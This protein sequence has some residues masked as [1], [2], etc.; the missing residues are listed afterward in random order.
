M[1]KLLLSILMILSTL[2]L[3]S[4]CADSVTVFFENFDGPTIKTRTSTS[5]G[6][7]DWSVNTTLYTSP[8]K[9]IHSPL[10]QTT[11]LQSQLYIDTIRFIP[12]KNKIYLSFNHICKI[13]HLDQAFVSYRVSTGGTPGSP[14]WSSW[15][16]M[17]FTE[18]SPNYYGEATAPGA[19][20]AG[21]F[22]Q[23]TYPTLWQNNNNNATP[24]NS[25]WK[26]EL[27][28]ISQYIV[29]LGD[30]QYFEI[31]FY[32]NRMFQSQYLVP[33]GWFLDDIRIVASDKELI[34]PKIALA[35]PLVPASVNHIGP[36]IVKA[37]VTDRPA[38]NV[39]PDSVK[40]YYREDGGA[41]ILA[42]KTQ[43]SA[44]QY[45]WTIPVQC[46][47]TNIQYQITAQ[48]SA[49]NPAIPLDGQFTVNLSTAGTTTNGVQNLG[50]YDPPFAV[51]VGDP[52]PVEVIIKNRTNNPMTSATITL[53]LNGVLQSTYNW[54]SVTD[55][56]PTRPF[57][58]DFIDTVNIGTYTPVMGWDTVKVCVTHR[59]GTPNNYV[60]A[61][62]HCSQYIRFGCAAIL[63]GPLN[64]GGAN[65]DFNTLEDFFITLAN[66]GMNGPIIA[67]LASGTYSSSQFQF[68]SL[69]VG[70][71]ATNTIT[72][73]P[74]SG[75]AADVTIV[76]D[77]N[78]SGRGA[79]TIN[80]TGHLTFN[81]LTIQGKTGGT[82]SMGVVFTG[83]ICT[84]V[85]ITNCIINISNSTTTSNLFS[86]IARIQA[87]TGSSGD[88]E[89]EIRGNTIT[90]GTYGIHY[91]GTSPRTNNLIAIESNTIETGYTGIYTI[92]TNCP[93]YNKNKIKQLATSQLRFTGM[94]IE[95]SS[96]TTSISKNKIWSEN[97]TNVGILLNNVSNG[98]NGEILVSNN[99]VNARAL[100]ANTYGISNTLCTRMN[101]LHNT[102]RLFSTSTLDLT[103]CYYHTSGAI[104][105]FSN[106]ILVNKC[107][108]LNN[109]NYP[110]YYQTN[111]N[112][113]VADYNV[114]HSSGP[115]GY[116]IVA[117]NNIEEWKFAMNNDKDTATITI[118][119][120]F[121]NLTT[122]LN[123]S[124]FS[125]F[126]CPKNI[127]VEDDIRDS[128]RNC[129]VTH[130]GCYS[131]Y[132]PPKDLA[133]V[134][135][136]SPALGTCPQASYP[137][138]LKLFNYGCS[139]INFAN[140][141]ATVTTIATGGLTLNT[142]H[143]IN[144]GTLAPNNSMNITVN[145]GL[146][147][148]HN[149][150]V[151][152][153]FIVNYAGDE[154]ALNDTL[155]L[156]FRLEVIAPAIATYDETFSNGTT[157][158]W[159]IEQISGA[160]N[161]SFQEGISEYPT[162]APVYGTGRLFF[163][164]KNFLT[165][166]ASRA[167]MPV[168]DLTNSVNP[169][170]EV[171]YAHD[172][173]AASAAYNQEGVIVKISTDGGATWTALN[174]ETPNPTNTNTSI[175]KRGQT[176]I[177]GYTLPA[178]VKY[179]YDLSNYNNNGCVFICL[180][181]T[182]KRGNNIN[183]DRIRVRKIHTNDCAV[184]N[185]YTVHERPTVVETSPEIKAIVTNEGRNAQNNVQVTLTVSGANS[186][187]ETATIA[188]IPYN[189]QG[190]ATF[191]GAHLPN[192]G[193]N[194]I[195]VTCQN[196]ENNANNTLNALLNTTA[197][198]I[199]YADTTSHHITF[200][201]VT[202]IKAAAKYNVVDTVI[203]TS[204][205][206][207]PSNAMDAVGKRV[208]AFVS[209]AE[210]KIIT[211]SDITTLTSEMIDSW[212]TL[213]INNYA[214]TNTCTDFYIGI[215]TVDPGHY[216]T[217]QYESP[218]RDETFYFLSDTI[219]TPQTVGRFM[220]GATVETKIDKEFAILS[221]VNPKTDCDLGVEKIKIKIANNGPV[222][223]MP[224]TTLHY[225]INGGAPVTE[226][227]TDT[228]FGRQIKHFSFTV[229]YNFTNNQINIDDNYTVK[230]WVDVVDQDRVRFNDTIFKPIVSMGKAN[231]PIAPDT[232]L[233][234][235]STP[236]TLTAQLPPQIDP[237]IIQWFTKDEDNHFVGP[238]YQ[239]PGPY[240]TPN[241]IFFDTTYY[242][243]VA[244]G[245][246]YTPISGNVANMN[247]TQP[248]TFT[249]G[250][251]RGRVL[252]K[253]SD[254]GNYG[255][256]AKI[257]VNVHSAANGILG[258]PLK[259]YIKQ[260]ELDTLMPGDPFDFENEVA[261]ATLVLDEQYFFNTTGWVEF[262]I[263]KPLNYSSGNIL[264]YTE[265]N[266]GGNNCSAA[267]GGNAYA[268]FKTSPVPYSVQTR[269]AN[270]APNFPPTWGPVTANRM[271]VK[272]FIADMDCAS[273]KVP[274]QLHV[275]DKPT[276]DVQTDALVHPIPSPAATQQCALYQEHI[277][278]VY[279]NLLDIPIPANKV[280]AKAGFRNGTSGPYTWITH[281]I[282]EEFAPL[283]SKTVT[284]TQTYDF[285][286]PTLNRNIQFIILSDLVGESIVFRMNDTIKGTIVSTRTVTIPDE[287]IYTGNFTETFQIIPGI[288]GVNQYAFYENDTTSST[289]HPMNWVPNYTTTNLYDTTVYYMNARTPASPNC[290]T[291]KIP[292]T[293]NVA[294]PTNNHD[295][296]T[297]E[298]IDPISYTCGLL[299]TNLTVN[300]N[301]TDSVLIP[302][303]TFKVTAKFTGNHNVTVVDTITH[304][305]DAVDRL[306]ATQPT[307]NITFNNPV[308]LGSTLENR[309]YN[310]S[311]FTDPV[312][313]TY[314][315]Y[316]KNDTITGELR[317]PG[318]PLAPAN[319]VYTVP[320]GQTLTI[321]PLTHNSNAGTP[322]NKVTFYDT[323]GN[324]PLHSGT[325]YTT[326]NI[327]E[328]TQYKYDGRII[329]PGFESE[330]I[331]GNV[332]SQNGS[333]PFVFTATES[334]GA[335][336][337]KKDELGGYAAL[338]DTI[339]IYV[340]N[341]ITGSF[342]IQIYL[343]NVDTNLLAPGQYNWNTQLLNGATLV[344]D[345]TP[346]FSAGWL[347]IPIEGGFYYT[348][349]SLM[350]LTS[351]NCYGQPNVAA[352][353]IQPLPT[354]KYTGVPNNTAVI[355]RA[356][357]ASTTPVQ[358]SGSNQRITMRFAM[359]YTCESPK[360]NITINTNVPGV[361]LDV[362][363][364][365]TPITP[366]SN[367]PNNQTVVAT[368][369]NRGTSNA[370]GFTVGYQYGNN[371][372][373]E[374]QFSG[375][376][377]AGAT[378]NFTFNTPVDLS[379]VYFPASFMVYVRHN[380]DPF[381]GNDTL[382]IK[383]RQ[384]DPCDPMVMI[385]SRNE[386]GAH[387][388]KFKL[389]GIDHGPGTPIFNCPVNITGTGQY[390][391]FT[392]TVPPGQL[393]RGQFFPITIVNSFST[394][395][396]VNL[397]KYV[398]LDM[399]KDNQFTVDELI[400]SALNVPAPNQANQG[401][402]TTTGFTE[403][404][405]INS[406][407]GLTRLRVITSN[408][409]LSLSMAPCAAFPAGEV[410]DYAIE[411]LD[412]YDIDPGVTHVLHP[413]GNV[414][415]D[416]GAKVKLLV[417]N[418]GA[419]TITFTEDNP[420]NISATVS[421]PVNGT[422]NN[423][424]TSG[425]LNQWETMVVTIHNVDLSM[426]GNYIVDA[427]VEYD[428]D[429]F[430]INNVA[431]SI[432][433]VTSTTVHQLPLS[434]N[435]DADDYLPGEEN[436]FPPF[437]TATS[438]HANMKWD[439]DSLGT[440]NFP[441]AGPIYDHTFRNH[442][443]RDEGQYAV[444]SAPANTSSS[445]VATLST[446]CINFHYNNGY[447]SESDYWQ[448]IFGAANAT[449]KFYVEIGSG[450]YYVTLD[451]IIGRTHTSSPEY[452]LKRNIVMDPIDEN[453]RVRFVV[454]GRTGRIDP[455][456]D[457]IS[458][459][460]GKA[461]I[462]IDGFVYPL[463]FTVADDDC[464]I[465]GDSVFPIVTIKNVGRVT[466]HTFTIHYN[467]ALGTHIQTTPEESWNG[468][469][470]PGETL[471]YTFQHGVL[472]PS[473]HNYL[474]FQALIET[475]NDENLQNNIHTITA[476]TTVGIDD[477][478][479]ENGVILG[480]NMPNP[481]VN[482]TVI[483]FYTNNP[484]ETVLQIHS[485]EGKLLHS[486]V[487]YAEVGENNIEV[488]TSNFAPGVYTYTITINQTKLT[489]KMII[490]K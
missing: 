47:G 187:T 182:G 116:Y 445:A 2:V 192:N 356:G 329:S 14:T 290:P 173:T 308:T 264:I 63:S 476:C 203:V 433:T 488:N 298:L 194:N 420:L 280:L 228:I 325:S 388:S 58:L 430:T 162:I 390:S 358:F 119:P 454:T 365:V 155:S 323:S 171:W 262:P 253:Q 417:K 324:D 51:E 337:Y 33:T 349:N 6:T 16:N 246:L 122:S 218:T 470:K 198:N 53:S 242:V 143:T 357:V 260:T 332:A 270:Q 321:S 278:V 197:N 478:Q 437:W 237:G 172:N 178:W 301:N 366:N 216:L 25:W 422:Y 459:K 94:N 149:Q 397:Y 5:H 177:T 474:Q 233:V 139:T 68:N 399:N 403:E 66:C 159:K 449:C 169:I 466:I 60:P 460:H 413:V 200:G 29:G 135:M 41:P 127:L 334:Q 69:F 30:G 314:Q 185:I 223:I 415:A 406:Q 482:E 249:S 168:M 392:E 114:Y 7:A 444:V 166:T 252:Y 95:R 424:I 165:N 312:D 441:Q 354:F 461:D 27:I 158:T 74:Q 54:S 487:Y 255:T 347:H 163:N 8:S 382:R 106:N 419:N 42:P 13:H 269:T 151:N 148:P 195:S 440:P 32:T 224:G 368:I 425:T 87:A 326:P 327:Y 154:R 484:G 316:R 485:I 389:G 144:T 136:I 376:I 442:F 12:G 480:Q 129:E 313:P 204:V 289:L 411:I 167:I 161:W 110:I 385:G 170:L 35:P 79:I 346:N 44:T 295:L 386:A 261:D 113:L 275:P 221:L 164:S 328:A 229:P 133:L 336:L 48:D 55:Y 360:A 416:A 10:Y 141:P 272:F 302:A 342:P 456:I 39:L 126:E 176:S 256:I 105:N 446:Q 299:S 489:H 28:D 306:P 265:T 257:A 102:I 266:C 393:V 294:V 363:H 372:P 315:P 84:N 254:I 209:N 370:S 288:Q 350:V 428:D 378:S 189:G 208:R 410:E 15:Q 236:A 101:Y 296:Q 490:Q 281:L 57:C 404:I 3:H 307:Q 226:T 341:N 67:K 220:I 199:N 147:I 70:Q 9:S 401:N 472:V 59:N 175:L 455:A 152:F 202:P 241:L 412:P 46:N 245:T 212:V 274:V 330:V 391:D 443:L 335:V 184:Q 34:P 452:Y 115:V 103:A 351:H 387:I 213:P 439:V 271:I 89:I 146:A 283:E 423:V 232:I 107:E 429:E 11:N 118:D 381:K 24:Q 86:G 227:I 473:L 243:S 230:V 408:Q 450:E 52:T 240:T 453:A 352:L 109:L 421:G 375:A 112:T 292:V 438:T 193:T 362:T 36:Y 190:V 140:T 355:Y 343:K 250:Y 76:D 38:N 130:R 128:L 369:K 62:A 367:Y 414:C 180:E 234:N 319:L 37:N 71:S 322:L 222:N 486:E 96:T 83:G 211:T 21:K 371:P 277:Q 463:D 100:A 359:N 273:E 373:V 121:E 468:I 348:G 97:N 276:Y 1:K 186:Y 26:S 458:F 344:Y 467:A 225:S 418:F 78:V 17:N 309:I 81:N 219:Y 125:G 90:G 207:Y 23:N 303:G 22:S 196:D 50:I 286:A 244:P 305:F 40:L 4:Q 407:T 282:D 317:V 451:S 65:A 291:K 19:I 427:I 279:T 45:Q 77:Q 267:S 91:L 174:P 238:L 477:I 374:Q 124:D 259:I 251:S 475:V 150:N 206:F 191:T 318:S 364:I 284:F 353:N 379:D 287:L 117:R 338:I 131:T 384:I 481:A 258:V 145:Q 75:N 377:A 120:P 409:N 138:T 447:P 436:P 56:H 108:S 464:V 137:V 111:P 123:L 215:E 311:I 98:T 179:T 394:S 153:T 457:D 400:F 99:E 333:F 471:E 31:R 72:F 73:E 239:G 396:G 426:I 398:F 339:S 201:S 435:F 43:L 263:E 483:P 20:I 340:Q 64:I 104:I 92:F 210:G 380:N 82:W 142:T 247:A 405:K 300:Y 402:A 434:I 132:V 465:K 469:L 432:A 85:K 383:L 156:P 217:A 395:S 448:H 88:N 361:D 310:Y 160:G 80:G 248:F 18:T 134:D 479:I 320:Y 297:N 462:A 49:C 431:S 268:R 285:S 304:N 231:L 183:I 331:V 61:S 214:L 157:L 235:Y 345:G 293:I 188:N 181:A 205:K 93:T